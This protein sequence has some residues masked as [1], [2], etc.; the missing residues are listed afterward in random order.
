M[1]SYNTSGTGTSTINSL[2]YKNEVSY[3][4]VCFS[5]HEE[6]QSTFRLHHIHFLYI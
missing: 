1:A 6:L 5:V 2:R 4:Y 3:T